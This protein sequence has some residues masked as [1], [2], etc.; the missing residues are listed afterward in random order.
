[1]LGRGYGFA[2]RFIS[3]TSLLPAI[4]AY[5]ENFQPSEAFPKSHEAFDRSS[6]RTL[7]PTRLVCRE[8]T[9]APHVA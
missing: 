5:R 3:P 6:V 4:E 1:M 7:V 8:T 2:S 9:V